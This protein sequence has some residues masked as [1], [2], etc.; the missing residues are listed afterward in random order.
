MRLGSKEDESEFAK[1]ASGICSLLESA[2]A[3]GADVSTD[4]ANN[5][6]LS[7]GQ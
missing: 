3:I 6:L 7:H 5:T 4:F 1:G 2:G